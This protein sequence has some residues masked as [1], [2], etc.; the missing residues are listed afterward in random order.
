MTVS[1]LERAFGGNAMIHV[2]DRPHFL[3]C[4]PDHFAV[5]YTINPWMDPSSWARDDQAL[6]LSSRREW[7]ALRRALVSLGAAVELAE[8]VAGL[9]DLVFTANAAVVLDRKVLLAKF[10]HP[11]RQGEEEH[12]ETAFRTLQARG[13]VDA[14]QR[15][16]GG[17]RL[18]GA[19][20]CVWDDTRQ[21][22]WTGH[23]PR[24]DAAA[25]HVVADLF[26]TETVAL[27]LADPRFYHLDTALCPLPRGEVMFVPEAFTPAGRAMIHALVEPSERIEVP[28][29]DSVSLAANTVALGDTLVM[30][31]CGEE[32]RAKLAERGYRALV[33]PLPSFLRSGGAAFCLTLRLDRV[34]SRATARRAVPV[35]AA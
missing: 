7:A 12:F 26:A 11:Q 1:T 30:P 22:F 28:L 23:G 27:E 13:L 33:V 29:S 8:P 34:S 6:A 25:R 18:E 19:G 2:A 4:P 3:M 14:V 32:L 9:P 5:T 35:G 20:D 10:R 16:P 17:V 31:A 21:L 15:P 24:S